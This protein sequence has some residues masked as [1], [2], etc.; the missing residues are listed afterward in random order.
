MRRTPLL[1]SALT[2]LLLSRAYA[3]NPPD[4]LLTSDQNSTRKYV[5]TGIVATVIGTSVIWSIDAWWQGRAHSFN[6][7]NEGWFDDYSLGIDKVGHAY[8]SYFYFNT[9]RN[10]LRWGGIDDQDALWWSAGLTEA[11]ALSLEIGDGFSTWG[12]SHEDFLS[13]TAGLSFGLL[14]T[15]VPF[16]QNFTLKWSYVPVRKRDGLNFTQHYDAH[17]YWLSCNVHNLLPETWRKYWPRFLSLA[18][19]YSTASGQN[20]REAVIGL[21]LNLEAF[22][23]ADP[24]VQL[25]QKTLNM[26]HVP[27]P[28]VKLGEEKKPEY[29]LFHLE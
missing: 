19:G 29:F 23:I 25:V 14:Q 20:K 12:F 18:V 2:I 24:D 1:V 21:D 7:Y 11:L 9:F 5:A 6:F 15:Q 26:I 27:M 22:D 28:G 13:N 17:T 4:T 10:T 3:D 16:L 8:A